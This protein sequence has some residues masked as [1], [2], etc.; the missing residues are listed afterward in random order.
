MLLFYQA[1]ENMKR[2]QLERYHKAVPEEKD[3]I[4]IN[5]HK[6]FA[7]A[8]ANCKPILELTPIKRGGVTYQVRR[9]QV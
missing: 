5:P 4:E 1:F 7:N 8:I 2:V 6:I 3:A 9:Y